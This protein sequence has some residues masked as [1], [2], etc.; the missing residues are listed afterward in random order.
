LA[1][2]RKNY[3]NLD[4]LTV[5]IGGARRAKARP[6]D[7]LSTSAAPTTASTSAAPSVPTQTDSQHFE[8]ML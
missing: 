3:W 8:A 4:D 6:A 7:L 5:F 2:I 1:Y